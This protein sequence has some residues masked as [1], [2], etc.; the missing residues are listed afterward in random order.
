MQSHAGGVSPSCSIVELDVKTVDQNVANG[1]DE[2]IPHRSRVRRRH[3]EAQ[4]GTVIASG[5]QM[6][7]QSVHRII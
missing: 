7:M 5:K 2:R 3:T 1:S 4:C 6:G